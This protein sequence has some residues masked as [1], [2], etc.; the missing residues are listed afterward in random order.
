MGHEAA[1]Y[2]KDANPY[3]RLMLACT[4]PT[5]PENMVP[6]RNAEEFFEQIDGLTNR[7]YTRGDYYSDMALASRE[8]IREFLETIKPGEF[9]FEV[10]QTLVIWAFSPG[11][12]IVLH[13]R[14][15]AVFRQALIRGDHGE[16]HSDLPLW[17]YPWMP[18]DQVFVCDGGAFSLPDTAKEA[19]R[20][21]LDMVGQDE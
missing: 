3:Y 9:P 11:G 17:V 1:L 5:Y 10:L 20:L 2:N 18:Q 14:N 4:R 13:P 15:H 8:E 7:R 12:G 19:E 6:P 21:A 16:I